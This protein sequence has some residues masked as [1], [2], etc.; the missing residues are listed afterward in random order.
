MLLWGAAL[1]GAI[2][3]YIQSFLVLGAMFSAVTL[4]PAAIVAF[5]LGIMI[6]A[7]RT[8]PIAGMA[9]VGRS[10]TGA[11]AMLSLQIHAH[12]LGMAVMMAAATV[13]LYAAYSH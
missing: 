3:T 7:G 6:G 9:C 12:R 13:F 1:G 11:Q 8:V 5:V 4:V 2:F 10:G